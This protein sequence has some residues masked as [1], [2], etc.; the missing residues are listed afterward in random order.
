LTTLRAIWWQNK[1]LLLW[2][3]WQSQ[4]PQWLK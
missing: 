2:L 3:Q 4:A 1:T